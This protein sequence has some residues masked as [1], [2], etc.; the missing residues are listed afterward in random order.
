MN[1]PFVSIQELAGSEPNTYRLLPFR[2]T[3]IDKEELLVNEAGEFLFAPSGT[4]QR[5]LSRN[6]SCSDELFKDLRAK[7]FVYDANSSPN[8]DLL[9]TKCRTKREFLDSGTKLH[10]FVVTLRCDHS[11]HYCQVS[12]QTANETEFDM[13]AETAEKSI[14]LMLASPGQF[15]TMEL[16]GGESLL[17]FPRVERMVRS[18]R[19]KA[20]ALGKDLDV[21]VTTNLAHLNEEMLSFFKEENVKVSTSLDGPAFIHNKNRPRPDGDSYERTVAGI[22]RCREE[23]GTDRV[24]ALMTTTR[25]SLGYPKQII[26][27]Y[28]SRDFHSLFLRPI[29][30]YGFAVKTRKKTG[31]NIDLFLDFYKSGLEHILEINRRGYYLVEVYTKLLLT[32]MLTPF[33][34]GYVDLQ[35]PAGAAWNV[36]VYN[37][38]GSVFASDESR[39][40]AEMHDLTFKLGN[41]HTHTRTELFS[42][43]AFHTLL[44]WGCNEG[45]PGCSD[46]AFQ[47][48]C[49][50]DPIFHQATQGDPCGLRPT[51]DFCRRNMEVMRYLFD[52]IRKNDLDVMRIFWSW[53][54]ERHHCEIADEFTA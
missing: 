43:D 23:L 42:S 1:R 26:D 32:K 25:H 24:A 19:R 35:S 28:V 10:I 45:L 37:Y 41:V 40:L 11:C 27:E 22:D 53:I 51:S 13:T 48:Y 2:F 34:T 16:Q 39:M 8:L 54:T 38:D 49:G 52:I 7:Q 31:Y 21:V 18:A 46:C 20:A 17:A 36:L 14:D 47:P 5:L 33:G 15:L 29:S 12:R 44:E 30:P 50:S 9:A 4:V 6:I 3:R